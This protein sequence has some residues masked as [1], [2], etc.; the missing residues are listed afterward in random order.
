MYNDVQNSIASYQATNA[1]L[2]VVSA[3]SSIFSMAMAILMIIAQWRI[4]EKAGEKGWKA[5]IPV[6]NVYILFKIAWKKSWFWINLALS[7]VAGILYT[8]AVICL[9]FASVDS[10]IGVAVGGI[11][12]IISMMLFIA[13]MVISIISY[14]KL[15]KAFGHGG[16]FAV[17]LIFLNFIFMLI[18]GFGSSRYV[19]NPNNQNNQYNQYNQ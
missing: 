13:P 18:L 16:G 12:L 7:A 3:I 17:G 6:Y 5:I 15:S 8:V 14:V 2:S 9:T 4:F 19:G 11:L 1:A 10:G